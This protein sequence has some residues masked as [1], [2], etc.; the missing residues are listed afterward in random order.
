[1]KKL[2]AFL[3]RWEWG[4]WVSIAAGVLAAFVFTPEPE[5][6]IEGLVP[7]WYTTAAYIGVVITVFGSLFLCLTIG[8]L[9]WAVVGNARKKSTGNA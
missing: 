7:G 9:I 5:K 6:A 4:Y 2:L 1:M 8:E 3:K